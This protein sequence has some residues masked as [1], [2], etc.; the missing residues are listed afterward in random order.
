MQ[1]HALCYEFSDIMIL[2]IDY[3]CIGDKVY[4]SFHG[5]TS[6]DQGHHHHHHRHHAAPFT[7]ADRDTLQTCTLCVVPKAQGTTETPKYV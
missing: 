6:F 5:V 1:T 7:D 4:T 3:Q 2:P